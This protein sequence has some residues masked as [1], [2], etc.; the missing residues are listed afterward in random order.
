MKCFR[1][2]YSSNNQV[3][4]SYKIYKH[5]RCSTYKFIFTR[6]EYPR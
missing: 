6:N 1:W 5:W 3:N 4:C 2:K